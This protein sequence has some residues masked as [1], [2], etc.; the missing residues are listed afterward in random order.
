MSGAASTYRVILGYNYAPSHVAAFKLL[1]PL[2]RG[3]TERYVQAGD[4]HLLF[5]PPLSLLHLLGRLLVLAFTNVISTK[6]QDV[7][8][9]RTIILG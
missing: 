1:C 5:A 8:S 3:M 2:Q 6:D 4:L 9:F 7:S